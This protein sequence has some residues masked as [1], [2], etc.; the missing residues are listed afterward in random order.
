MDVLLLFCIPL[1]AQAVSMMA[2]SLLVLSGRS[3][4]DSGGAEDGA[5]R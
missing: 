2:R 3:G 5:P 4:G 1:A